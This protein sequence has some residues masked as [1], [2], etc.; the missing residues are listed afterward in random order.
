MTARLLVVDDEPRTAELTAEL[1][2]RAGY[3]V[4]IAVSGTAALQSVRSSSPDLMLL[5][6]EMPDMEAPEVLDSL[7]SGADRIAF[8]VIILTGARHASGDQVLGIDHGAT[9]Y[10]VKGTDRQVLL[11]RIRGALRE[12]APEARVMVA[13]RLR[14]DLARGQAWLG[15]RDV[16]L[17]R[18]PLLM[19]QLLAGRPGEVVG[20][21]ELLERVWGTKYAGFE[22]SLE[23]AVHQI[24]RALNEPGW[25][26]TVRGIGYR[27]VA[28]P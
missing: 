24:R 16:K 10:I 14:I 8:P 7:R 25:I 21:A 18:R 5:D 13:G 23:Q 6:Y 3:M 19:L 15:D 11:A 22:H 17:E 20:R 26:E 12:S 4:E 2:R 27:F 1:L 9:D 28:Q